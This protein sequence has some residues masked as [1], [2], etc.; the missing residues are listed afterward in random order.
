MVN[1]VLAP[2]IAM[3]ETLEPLALAELERALRLRLDPPETAAE[4]RV[5][6]LGFLATL[7]AELPPAVG[8]RALPQLERQ[9]YVHRQPLEAPDAPDARRLVE[10]YGSWLRVC[11]AAYGLL[12]DGRTRGEA[13]PYSNQ[14]RGRKRVSKYTRE[15]VVEA[16]RQCANDLGRVPSSNGYQHWGFEL[17]RAARQRGEKLP[18]IPDIKIVYRFYPKGDNRWRLAVAD[19]QLNEAELA[20]ARV[21]RVLRL[22][23]VEALPAAPLELFD[24]T[25]IK[26][27]ESI[28]ID[29]NR[30]K[31]LARDGFGLLTL[32]QATELARLLGGSLDWLGGISLDR[33]TAPPGGAVFGLAQLDRAQAELGLTVKEL[34]ERLEMTLSAW[35]Q[36]KNGKREPFVY[37]LIVLAVW[38]GVKIGE[39]LTAP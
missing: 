29:A 28:G 31:T 22:A 13:A 30:K 17:K 33:G 38:M 35:T 4:R 10:R 32:A 14:S 5:A 24:Q 11:R 26:A 8:L 25:P 16:I 36:L 9:V 6:E 3:L 18:R 19:A 20:V 27:L 39:L 23:H 15:E 2:V 12:P 37:E 34:R 21:Q 7:L 1:P